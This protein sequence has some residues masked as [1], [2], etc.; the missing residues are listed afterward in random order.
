M[1]LSLNRILLLGTC[2]AGLFL[3]WNYSLAQAGTTNRATVEVRDAG[4]NFNFAPSTVTI[5]KGGTVTW[6]WKGRISHNVYGSGLNSG[7]RTKGQWPK[8]FTRTGTYS[9]Y[10]VIHPSMRGKVVVRSS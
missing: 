10:C 8:R 2:C 1:K 4:N 6:V 3:A 5:K 9:Y 7:F